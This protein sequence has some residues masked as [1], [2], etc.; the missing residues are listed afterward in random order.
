MP[1]SRPHV[2]IEKSIGDHLSP[3]VTLQLQYLTGHCLSDTSLFGGSG[4]IYTSK[5]TAY[6]HETTCSENNGYPGYFSKWWMAFL[7]RPVWI[8]VKWEIIYQVPKQP[9]ST[10]TNPQ[11]QAGLKKHNLSEWCSTFH[12]ARTYE[13]KVCAPTGTWHEMLRSHLSPPPRPH[14]NSKP[15]NKHKQ[16]TLQLFG[17]FGEQKV[18]PKQ[19]LAALHSFALQS[20]NM[21]K[22]VICHHRYCYHLQ[23]TQSFTKLWNIEKKGV[24]LLI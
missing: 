2:G 4:R 14:H 5:R 19:Q 21:I 1:N 7:E 23:K 10:K 17:L 3:E 22:H 16:S 8:C 24:I 13:S 9:Q 6:A 20:A 11:V 18:K 15:K 12:T